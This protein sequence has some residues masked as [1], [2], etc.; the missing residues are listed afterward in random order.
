MADV[1]ATQAQFENDYQAVLDALDDWNAYAGENGQTAQDT[2]AYDKALSGVSWTSGDIFGM[3]SSWV[4]LFMAMGYQG[5]NMLMDNMDETAYLM[6]VLSALTAC[7]NDIQTLTN[8]TSTGDNAGESLVD[9]AEDMDQMLALFGADGH[10]VEKDGTN[11][12]ELLTGGLG[13]TACNTMSDYFSNMRSDIF[14][15]GDDS[16]YNPDENGSYHFEC[17]KN[18]YNYSNDARITSYGEAYDLASQSGDPLGATDA[19]D[20]L[21][22]SLNGVLTTT[23]NVN[24]SEQAILTNQS[25]QLQT[26]EQFVAYACQNYNKEVQAYAAA[27]IPA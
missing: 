15:I 12:T 20:T 21:S 5:C 10:S 25:N 27:Q 24:E 17:D 14:V 6:N 3:G 23:Q 16:G 26:V 18:N 13:D 19:L 22:N 1:S 7:S 4:S 2:A 8:D 9:A 11:Y